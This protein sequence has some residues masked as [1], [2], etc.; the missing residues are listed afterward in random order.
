MPTARS[1]SALAA[2][3]ALVL[4]ANPRQCGSVRP[5][6]PRHRRR[7]ARRW[8]RQPDLVRSAPSVPVQSQRPA[9]CAAFTFAI[10]RYQ[11]QLVIAQPRRR[12]ASAAEVFRAWMLETPEKRRNGPRI[13]ALAISVLCDGRQ[14]H[15]LGD[16]RPWDSSEV[17]PTLPHVVD[18]VPTSWTRVFASMRTSGCPT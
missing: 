8:S 6:G 2:T 11:D 7:R 16:D 13:F 4:F 5:Y 1:T 14:T 18:R 12:P 17:T 3:S 9:G 15:C 10:S